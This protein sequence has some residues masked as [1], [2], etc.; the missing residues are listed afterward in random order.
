MKEKSC[1]LIFETFR[2]TLVIILISEEF[3]S[4][5]I[6][7]RVDDDEVSHERWNETTHH[8]SIASHDVLLRDLGIINQLNDFER[9][10]KVFLLL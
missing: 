2:Y 8:S 5:V 1:N 9:A 7:P 4:F 3:S 6:D 10:F